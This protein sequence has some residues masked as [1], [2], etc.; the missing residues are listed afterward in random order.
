MTALFF[1]QVTCL[2]LPL[3]DKFLI[4]LNNIK[5]QTSTN[6]LEIPKLDDI[7]CDSEQ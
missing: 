3:K 4:V 2:A 5:H 6:W 7:Q 1:Y